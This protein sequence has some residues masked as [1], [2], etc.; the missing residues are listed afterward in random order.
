MKETT[1]LWILTIL[2]PFSTGSAAGEPINRSGRLAGLAVVQRLKT[3]PQAAK[4]PRWKC[5]EEYDAF[6]A[7]GKE[8]TN[9][10][11]DQAI[12][13]A[14]AF[15]QRFPASDFK[16]G[17]YISEMK[18]YQQIGKSDRA[19][20]AARNALSLDPDSLEALVFLSYVFPLTYKASDP[21]ATSKLH[22]V[23]SDAAHGLDVLQTLQKPAQAT[24]AEF[25]FCVNDWRAL[26]NGT[27]GF[28]DLQRNDYVHAATALEAASADD[29]SN[30][31]A[32][33]RLALAYLSLTA[34][35]YKPDFDHGIW[36]LAR[37]EALARVSKH[38]SGEQIGE[39]LRRVYIKYHGNEDGLENMIAQA[40]KAVIPPDG[41]NVVR[42]ETPKRIIPPSP[43]AG[44]PYQV[45]QA[46]RV[47]GRI[48]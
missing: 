26:F 14:E 20:E 37:A 42:K 36:F 29:P 10:H 4:A 15:L 23:E 6:A 9:G 21:Y 17:A 24:D 13:L 8:Q 39:Y 38:L 44:P 11:L 31:E 47:W 12:S 28:A 48:P 43:P 18:D 35:D 2:F 3:P 16:L 45:D 46:C 27:I 32:I 5:Q 40:S 19:V 7:I 34:P 1:T 33:Y 25:S 30:V 41:F 22:R